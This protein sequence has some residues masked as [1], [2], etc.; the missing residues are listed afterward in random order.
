MESKLSLLNGNI[1]CFNGNV[2]F[3][4]R[5]EN[6]GKAG[7]S[8]NARYDAPKY[9]FQNQKRRYYRSITGFP[10]VVYMKFADS[11]RISKLG[12]SSVDR[13][14]AYAPRSFEIVGSFDCPHRWTTILHVAESGFPNDYGNGGIFKTWVV[15]PQNRKA[16]ECIGLKIKTIM[17]MNNDN[18]RLKN[19]TMW[20]EL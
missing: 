13:Y 7:A 15:P 9:A 4:V 8:S 17:D 18:V 10:Q 20:E 3:S 19:I 16:F 5:M 14:N 11:H 2:F 12:F 1:V 6:S